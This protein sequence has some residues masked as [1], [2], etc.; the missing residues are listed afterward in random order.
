MLQFVKTTYFSSLQFSVVQQKNL[1][2]SLPLQTS[3]LA[4]MMSMW[5]PFSVSH[6]PY[7]DPFFADP[8]E[9]RAQLPAQIQL[10]C[11][12]LISFRK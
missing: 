12:P 1:L 6:R 7:A 3:L 5:H 10:L 11:R 4:K 8:F 2:R 9:V